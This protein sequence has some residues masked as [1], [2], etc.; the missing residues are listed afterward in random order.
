MDA[1]ELLKNKRKEVLAALVAHLDKR[2]DDDGLALLLELLEISNM[3][4]TLLADLTAKALGGQHE[5]LS[6][7][8]FS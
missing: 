5:I 3:Q 6:C 1:S 7:R 2:N 4:Y 8:S